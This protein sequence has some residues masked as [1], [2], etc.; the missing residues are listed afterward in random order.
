M[1]EIKEG[2]VPSEPGKKIGDNVIVDLT[3]DQINSLSNRTGLAYVKGMQSGEIIEV[4]L[5]KGNY[6]I[7]AWDGTELELPFD[8]VDKK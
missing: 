8:I 1:R 7:K 2:G 5:T 4:N 3:G 6:K